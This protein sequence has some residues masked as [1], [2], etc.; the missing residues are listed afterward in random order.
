MQL[1]RSDLRNVPLVRCHPEDYATRL[2]QQ[3]CRRRLSLWGR[4]T[5]RA[6]IIYH[7]SSFISGAT[8][9]PNLYYLGRTPNGQAV[10]QF[11]LRFIT[12]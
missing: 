7:H 2:L 12:Y 8:R 1:L 6:S 11:K 4:Q 9:D 3:G 5:P 10:S